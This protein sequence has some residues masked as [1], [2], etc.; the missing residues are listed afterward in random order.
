MLAAIYIFYTIPLTFA[1]SLVSEQNI[2]VVFPGLAHWSKTSLGFSVTELLSGL[3][4]SMITT[5]FLASCPVLFKVRSI[6]L[7]SLESF[8]VSFCSRKYASSC[9]QVHIQLWI[10]SRVRRTGRICSTAVLLVF[11]VDHSIFWT[12]ADIYDFERV[13][14]RSYVWS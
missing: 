6:S 5:G 1:S 3:I 12:A 10:G 9:V 4:S 14:Q 8:R 11:H 7:L 2:R 13:R